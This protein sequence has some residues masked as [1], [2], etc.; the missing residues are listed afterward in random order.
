MPAAGLLAPHR[1]PAVDATV[2]NGPDLQAALQSAQPGATIVLA[3]GN[4]GDVTQFE[5]VVPGVTLR[6]SVPMRSVLRA[7]V[8]ISGDRV[9]LHDLA[10]MGEG[11]EGIYMAA[12]RA[13]AKDDVTITSADVEVRGCDFGFFIGRAVFIR[14][15]G[16]VRA[17]IHDCK[18][19]DNRRNPNS[20]QRQ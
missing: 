5:M 14:P 4:Y 2:H 15:P 8:V 17:Y 18:F 20:S 7:P 13:C 12:V 3:P 10:F 19:H 11:D 16:G 1:R 6:A 9:S